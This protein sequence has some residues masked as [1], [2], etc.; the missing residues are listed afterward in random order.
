MIFPLK[1]FPKSIPPIT[2]RYLASN[3]LS[4]LMINPLKYRTTNSIEMINDR[5]AGKANIFKLS[6]LFLMTDNV[7]TMTI[8]INHTMLRKELFHSKRYFK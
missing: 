8:I 2:T 4:I 5:N 6:S 3:R 1:E 7:A